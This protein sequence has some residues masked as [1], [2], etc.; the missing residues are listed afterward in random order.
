VDRNGRF[1]DRFDF[2]RNF[3]LDVLLAFRADAL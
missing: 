1:D 3:L 2:L